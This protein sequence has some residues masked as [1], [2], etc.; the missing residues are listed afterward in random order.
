MSD[1]D[2]PSGEAMTAPI[3]LRDETVDTESEAKSAAPAEA[4]TRSAGG[5]SRRAVPQRRQFTGLSGRFI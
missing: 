2:G 3:V 5:Q 1:C 4:R